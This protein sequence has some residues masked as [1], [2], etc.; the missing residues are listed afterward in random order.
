MLEV[1]WQTFDYEYAQRALYTSAMVGV[2][3]GILGCFIILRKM[4]LIG[5]ALSHAILPGVVVGFVL[6]GYSLTGFFIGSVSAGLLAAVCITWIQRNVKT[7]EDAAIGI[8]F[9]C[10]FS[11]GVIGIS[12]ITRREGVHLDL[13]DFLFGNILGISSQDMILTFMVMSYTVVCV[14]FFYRYLFITTFDSV[15]A[16]TLGISPSVIH[17]FLM[18]LLSFSVVASLQSVGVILVV[19][20]LI[21][22][23]STAYLLTY[24]MRWMLVYAALIGLL[25]TSLGLIFA[26]LLETPPGP[27][28]TLVA[29][30]FYGLAVIFSPQKGLFV[31]ML[32]K[33]RRNKVVFIED[34]LKAAVKLQE[35]R[36]LTPEALAEKLAMPSYRIKK[37]LQHL[38]QGQ[39]IHIEDKNITLTESG[40]Q[41]GYELIR[42]HRLWETYLA[43][44]IGLDNEQVH[45]PA[46]QLEHVLPEKFLSKVEA[47][48]GYPERDP[49][50]SFIPPHIE[51]AT[52]SLQ[53]LPEQVWAMI[54]PYQKDKNV[55][56]L[57]W[58]KG[59]TPGDPIL[60]TK[61][62]PTEI[63]II[64]NQTEIIFP[65]IWGEKIWLVSKR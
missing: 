7:H 51:K 16:S 38:A 45:A 4:A 5:D 58:E 22:P 64:S 52:F 61:G 48:L 13:K 10:M 59:L 37:A 12:Q 55:V 11:I 29:T 42:A 18:L 34:V 40:L 60:K 25:S 41:R 47:E 39:H 31:K 24:K 23:A 49:H 35:Q 62:S 15:T 65:K 21:T 32:R 28:M 19:A 17:Y 54:S 9:T 50:G 26:I 33:I 57:L 56:Q 36:R 46:E 1:L 44:E 6:V 14:V 3:C 43:H 53:E 27:A 30:A 63:A 20:M 2:M 8:V